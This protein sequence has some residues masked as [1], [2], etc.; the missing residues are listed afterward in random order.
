MQAV[1]GEDHVVKVGM[2]GAQVSRVLLGDGEIETA[3]RDFEQPVFWRAFG[4]FDAK[5]RV[6]GG[7]ARQGDRDD[8][9]RRRLKHGNAH[10]SANAREGLREVC[11]C[12]F[13]A[14][15]YDLAV[16]NQ[17]P[18]LS[19]QPYAPSGLFKQGDSRLFFQRF[20]LL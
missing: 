15:E 9:V 1:T 12:L 18:G 10:R 17:G 8:S 2:T 13:Q 7:E 4:E 11:F 5:V 6:L 20:Q 16:F 19:R 14:V 3:R